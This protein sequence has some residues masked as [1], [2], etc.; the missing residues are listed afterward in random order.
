MKDAI[1]YYWYWRIGSCIDWTVSAHL[2][3]GHVISGGYSMHDPHVLGM[4][5]QMIVAVLI[6]TGVILLYC[7]LKLIKGIAGDDKNAITRRATK[8]PAID[9]STHMG[10]A[11]NR[12]TCQR[13]YQ[14]L[15]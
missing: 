14:H 7:I 9:S 4:A 3:S 5:L 15:A 12:K 10:K 6:T 13:N 2:F 8:N 11:E 1:Y